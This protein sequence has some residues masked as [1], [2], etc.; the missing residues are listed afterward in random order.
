MLK[1]T[2]YKNGVQL[3]T[4]GPVTSADFY[5][6]VVPELIPKTTIQDSGGYLIEAE[7]LRI[8]GSAI[9]ISSFS[10]N[11][12]PPALSGIPSPAAFDACIPLCTSGTM[13]SPFDPNYTRTPLPNITGNPETD[14]TAYDVLTQWANTNSH[15]DCAV[16][17]Q[18]A[19]YP[20]K[21]RQ[22][23]VCYDTSNDGL[24]SFDPLNSCS[25][26]FVS[27]RGRIGCLAEGTEI[28]IHEGEVT[29]VENLRPGDKV[30]NPITRREMTIGKVVSG[31][32]SKPLL[33]IRTQLQNIVMTETHPVLTRVGRKSAK[34]LTNKDFVQVEGRWLP[35]LSLDSLPAARAPTVWN[36]KL[37]DGEGWDDHWI[38]ANGMPVERIPSKGAFQESLRKKFATV[39]YGLCFEQK[40]DMIFITGVGVNFENIAGNTITKLS[41]E[42]ANVPI[43]KRNNIDIMP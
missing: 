2:L 34:Q 18:G 35:I 13:E 11:I 25:K 31:P 28:A 30:W 4:V 42:T 26:S 5:G 14:Q 12:D 40:G 1:A 20:D 38:L 32:E 22:V 7:A 19:V 8:D 39:G 36:I 17:W 33:L 10:F 15:R 43:P 41:N 23:L 9:A 16:R 27:G 3:A 24:Y 29:R 6:K 21:Y 37:V